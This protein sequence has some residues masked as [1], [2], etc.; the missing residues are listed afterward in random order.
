MTTSATQ[1]N[2]RTRKR[3]NMVPRNRKKRAPSYLRCVCGAAA[4]AVCGLVSFCGAL[5]PQPI[6]WKNTHTCVAKRTHGCVRDNN[7]RAR[8]RGAHLCDARAPLVT[9]TR[10]SPLLL[11]LLQIESN[12][13]KSKR[14]SSD[15]IIIVQVSVAHQNSIVRLSVR[16]SARAVGRRWRSSHACGTTQWFVS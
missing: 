4:A 6:K 15:I 9:T 3:R 14:T 11:L 16:A 12:Q 2:K 10:P 5:L 1:T 7:M 8:A 13:I